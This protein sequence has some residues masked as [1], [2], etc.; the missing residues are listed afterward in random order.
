MFSAYKIINNT[1]LISELTVSIN[2]VFILFWGGKK[3]IAEII[4]LSI[5]LKYKAFFF[6][7]TLLMTFE[8]H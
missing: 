2:L 1:I 7:L 6:L 5:Y 4:L 8:P 3:D